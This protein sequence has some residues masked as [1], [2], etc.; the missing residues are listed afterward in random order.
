MYKAAEVQLV[1]S[2][3]TFHTEIIFDLLTVRWV[4]IFTVRV[5]PTL[6]VSRIT[7]IADKIQFNINEHFSRILG[8][9]WKRYIFL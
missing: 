7:C 8:G 2:I 6:L 3:G 9:I 4:L 5:K 1:T